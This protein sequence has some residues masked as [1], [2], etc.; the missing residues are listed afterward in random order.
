LNIAVYILD[1]IIYIGIFSIVAMSLNLEYGFTGL[2]NFGKV[3]FFLI[4]AYTYAL[5]SQ[6]GIPFYLSLICSGISAAIGGLIISLPALRLRED[7]LAIVTLTVGEILRL[8]IKTESWIAGGV[9]GISIKPAI[10]ISFPSGFPSYNKILINSGIQI[11]LIFSILALCFVVLQLLTRSPYG[12]VMRALRDDE[13]ATETMGKSRARYKAQVFMLG[14]AMAGIAGGLFAQYIRFIDPYMFMP[15]ITFTIWIMSLV[16][17]PANFT[18]ALLGAAL[19]QIFDRGTN[20]IKDYV[21][22][23]IDP[24][25]LQYILFG[26]LILLVLFFRPQGLLRE[27]KFTTRSLRLTYEK[28]RSDTQNTQSQ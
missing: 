1:I 13:L 3:A 7:Y 8:I 23:P 20:I 14:S 25:N 2:G 22:L 10:S 11:A 18:G 27:S 9:W 24:V 4:G 19:V 26:I 15:I 21:T 16:G 12:R 6:A 28:R 5:L 17:G